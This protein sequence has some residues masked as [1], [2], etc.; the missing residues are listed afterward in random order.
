MAPQKVFLGGLFDVAGHDL[1]IVAST[2]AYSMVARNMSEEDNA[3]RGF[4][5]V[6][7]HRIAKASAKRRKNL[8]QKPM[9]QHSPIFKAKV[10]HD[11]AQGKLCLQG[12]GRQ[13]PPHGLWLRRPTL[14]I[15]A[16]HQLC[17]RHPQSQHFH[18]QQVQDEGSK[19]WNSYTA[20]VYQLYQGA[21]LFEV[22]VSSCATNG[23]WQDLPNAFL[24]N[25]SVITIR[26]LSTEPMLYAFSGKFLGH[27]LI[28]SV[29]QFLVA[30]V[31]FV[32]H[33]ITGTRTKLSVVNKRSIGCNI[34]RD[35]TKLGRL[36][37]G[38]SLMCHIVK[39]SEKHQM[40][41]ENIVLYF[42][43]SK[44]GQLVLLVD[45]HLKLPGVL[46]THRD[47]TIILL[48]NEPVIGHLVLDGG[49]LLCNT[50]QLYLGE[51]VQG[52]S[53]GCD[54]C[55]FGA[56]IFQA[57]TIKLGKLI[58]HSVESLVFAV[59]A[60][61][62]FKLPILH[63][64]GQT[65]N[66]SGTSGSACNIIFKFHF[67]SPIIEDPF[68]Y[69]SQLSRSITQ[70]KDGTHTAGNPVMHDNRKP[71]YLAAF[72]SNSISFVASIVVIVLLL[73]KQLHNKWWLRVMNMTI[74][75]DLLGLLVAYAAGSS[76][77]WKTS[78]Y[79]SALIVA[80]LAYFAIHVVLS[81]FTRSRSKKTAPGPQAS[82]AH[83]NEEGNGGHQE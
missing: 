26:N 32:L 83:P 27:H 18:H 73:P 12:Y 16:L 68:C 24:G 81:S 4:L 7:D 28:R 33:L 14:P 61:P 74:A 21:N 29:V 76:R 57:T 55:R 17:A 6:R 54:A 25:Y 44:A 3:L 56:S 67:Y 5:H 2:P 72:Y 66:G 36:I 35:L 45:D 49:S 59:P 52:V 69:L 20:G 13:G 30:W 40:D 46:K 19:W 37:G 31:I 15:Q 34:I 50:W 79:V 58:R 65:G 39:I 70:S 75:F 51:E 43:S 53:V 9:K 1:V 77:T 78:V 47:L 63:V 48:R 71:R 80:V 41:N 60:P 62:R 22:E 38:T 64:E 11:L 82:A 23:S 8:K 42:S 10:V